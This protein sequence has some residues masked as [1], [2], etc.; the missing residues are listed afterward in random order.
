[1]GL[2]ID[3]LRAAQRGERRAREQLL[4]SKLGLVRSVALRYRDLGVPFEDLVQEGSI[5]LLEAIDHYD[6]SHDASFDSFARFRVRKAIRNALTDQARLIRLP[7]QIVE[8]RR[9]LHR[10][11][12]EFA[13]AAAGR[14]PTP[15]QLA[16]ATGLSVA[17][18]LRARSAGQAPISLDEPVLPD[19]SPLASVIA[20]PQAVDPELKA[21]ECEQRELLNTA[22]ENLPER[23]RRVIGRRWGMGAAQRSNAEVAAELDLS[24]RRTQTIGQDALYELRAALERATVGA[25]DPR[26]APPVWGP[27]AEVS[28]R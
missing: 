9:A 24:P 25:A 12:A 4:S 28:A 8:R 1:M 26:K 14:A 16:A 15:A 19:G 20:D 11:E 6:P 13:A 3:V 17:A 23:Q 21:L 5:G 18:V 7:K 27:Q 2:S 10:A 22:I